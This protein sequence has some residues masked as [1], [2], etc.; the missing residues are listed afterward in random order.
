MCGRGKE[1]VKAGAGWVEMVPGTEGGEQR[2][3]A[4]GG[5][6]VLSPRATEIPDTTGEAAAKPGPVATRAGLACSLLIPSQVCLIHPS[7]TLL[8]ATGG[9]DGARG[10][11]TQETEAGLSALAPPSSSLPNPCMS[12]SSTVLPDA[13]EIG[14]GNPPLSCFLFKCHLNF[15]SMIQRCLFLKEITVI[16]TY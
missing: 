8:W 6:C 14:V 16:M 1:A 2:K 12:L 15:A 11:A 13:L 3:W 10:W 4:D 5:S 9:E 7:P